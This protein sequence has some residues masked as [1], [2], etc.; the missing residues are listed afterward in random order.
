[1]YYLTNA[2]R[3][4]EIKRNIPFVEIENDLMLSSIAQSRNNIKLYC[5]DAE[6][7]WFLS[8]LVDDC[9]TYIDFVDITIGCNE[10]ISLYNADLYYFGNVLL[11]FDGDVTEKQLSRIPERTRSNLGNIILLPGGKRPEQVIYEYIHSLDADHDFWSGA[12]QSLGLTWDYFN[13]RGPLSEDYKQVDE[14]SKYK[15]WFIEHKQ[16]FESIHLMDFWKRDNSELVTEFRKQFKK[17][18]NSLAKRKM[19]FLIEE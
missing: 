6:A 14:R 17:A 9:L 12:T 11:V 19:T 15:E 5:E 1:M 18:Y 2:N 10:L 13:E 4:L 8:S 7:R 3:R 16:Y